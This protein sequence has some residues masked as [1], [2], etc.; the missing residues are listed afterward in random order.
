MKRLV[1]VLTVWAMGLVGVAT[2]VVLPAGS[3]SAGMPA[4]A[5]GII[6]AAT[7]S[8]GQGHS[9]AVTTT[10]AVRC[11]GLN[12][13]GQLGNGTTTNS[14]VPVGVVGLGSGVV[15]VSTGWSYS[16][17]VT[18]TGA[19]KCWGDNQYGEL[20]DGTTTSSTVPVAV[21]GLSSGVA[22]VSTSLNSGMGGSTGAHSCAVTTAGAVMCWGTNTNGELG[23][24]TT[25]DSLVPVA[26]SGLSST[27]AQVSVNINFSCA[28]TTAGAAMCWGGN[29]VGT[30]GDGTTTDS[31]VPVGVTGLDTGVAAISA[32]F[33]F[34]CVVTT[35]GA[36]KC[37]GWNGAGSLGDGTNTDSPV[38][39][40][41]T[42]HG[43]VVAI[44][45]GWWRACAL[46]TGGAVKCWGNGIGSVPVG[47]VGLSS[48]AATVS[49]GQNL[50]CAVTTAGA[51][52]CWGDNND[53]DNNKYGQLGDGT[54]TAS[55]VPVYVVGFAA[56]G[57]AAVTRLSDFNRDGYTDLVARDAAGLLWL[58][59]GNGA[60]S[61]L[62]RRQMGSGWNTMNTIVTPG[63]VTGDGNGDIIA[64]DTSGLLWLYPGNGAFGVGARR[65]IGSGWTSYTITNA[66]NMNTA[67]RP[68]LLARDS[69]GNLWLYPLSGNAVFGAR[70]KIGS[71]WG[72]LLFQG[73]GDLSGDGRA[74]ILA[75]NS[76]G[77]LLLY[78]GNGAGGVAAGIVVGSGFAGMTAL[79]TPGNWDR[80][81]GNDV[82]ARDAA[83][84]LWLF[85]G[86]NASGWLA[87]RQIGSGWNGMTY[88]G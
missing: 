83:G 54:T 14:S 65:Q 22:A 36:A 12:D 26:V 72:S 81:A 57:V 71:G 40:D 7:I 82:L 23:D 2:S 18:T 75:R 6:S 33:Q 64:K 13:Y 52:K 88:I 49:T 11:W 16:C 73:P 25:T 50:S 15:A 17:A 20:G 27:A 28:V 35:T 51:A 31:L 85:P 59:T 21:S 77:Q 79:V 5:S 60:G 86:N 32:G 74:D 43:T 42:G 44:S 30:L 39:V 48:G 87:K 56:I 69:A 1:V 58:Y 70:T 19:V 53:T 4:A 76:A 84:L 45:A 38:P 46:T 78:R 63:D 10:G 67:G 3:A 47:V 29:A 24:G 61:F 55:S 41:V 8:A 9:C 37:W 66:A 80:T 62:A 34:A 68:D